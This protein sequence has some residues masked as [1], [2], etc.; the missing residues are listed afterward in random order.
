MT[1]FL[2]HFRDVIITGLLILGFVYFGLLA[3]SETADDQSVMHYR[4]ANDKAIMEVMS[5]K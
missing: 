1:N 3:L 4:I 5:E 2:R